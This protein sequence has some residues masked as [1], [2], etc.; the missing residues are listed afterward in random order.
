M[1]RASTESS[2]PSSRDSTWNG[3]PAPSTYLHRQLDVTPAQ[4]PLTSQTFPCITNACVRF[5]SS[6]RL[7]ASQQEKG[8]MSSPEKKVLRS[9]TNLLRRPRALI[10][11]GSWIV[12]V[13]LFMPCLLVAAADTPSGKPHI[14][15]GNVRIE[16]DNRLRTRVVARF[17][18]TETVM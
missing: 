4:N 8:S 9:D 7:P 11:L 14:Q 10:A 6:L 1:C 17:G 16:F 3:K 5:H 15:G 18:K 2:T 13:A 12:L